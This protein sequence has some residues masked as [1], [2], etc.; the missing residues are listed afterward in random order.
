MPKSPDAFRTISEVSEWLETPA[1]VLRF[2]ES[3]FTQVKPVKRAGGRRYYRPGDME[4][5]GGIKKLLH[6]DGMTIKGVQKVLREQGVRHVASLSS[7]VDPEEEIADA[8][9]IEAEEDPRDS[10]VAFRR[11]PDVAPQ[12]DTDASPNDAELAE[13][14]TAPD[15][16]HS[17]QPEIAEDADVQPVAPDMSDPSPKAFDADAAPAPVDED[18]EAMADT[19]QT[20]FAF[21]MPEAAASDDDAVLDDMTDWDDG[22]SHPETVE[23]LGALADDPDETILAPLPEIP[24]EDTDDTPEIEDVV[25]HDIDPVAGPDPVEPQHDDTPEPEPLLADAPESEPPHVEDP[26]PAPRLAD[27]PAPVDLDDASEQEPS[28]TLDAAAPV[29]PEPA[30]A[31]ASQSLHLPDFSRSEE[32]GPESVFPGLLAYAARITS[33]TPAQAEAIAAHL[34]KLKAR[35]DRRDTDSL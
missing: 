11:E 23:P 7:P 4:L 26:E 34:P 9:F 27:A 29:Q 30:R 19:D 25:T 14:H 17:A 35:A 2:W 21:D 8:P 31:T 10:V 13:D 6:D 12:N 33:L 20:I 18:K 5:L 15:D 3:K 1:H 24:A 28:E 22:E 32:E 16:Q